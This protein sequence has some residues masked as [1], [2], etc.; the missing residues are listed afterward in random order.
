LSY[1][2]NLFYCCSTPKTNTQNNQELK[3]TQN[4]QKAALQVSTEEVISSESTQQFI[5]YESINNH[6]L[7][8]L[9]IMFFQRKSLIFDL[10]SEQMSSFAENFSTLH[11]LEKK[12]ELQPIKYGSDYDFYLTF[13]Q[14][15]L[16]SYL[17]GQWEDMGLKLLNQQKDLSFITVTKQDF[18][19][20][21]EH[22]GK[23]TDSGFP[24]FPVQHLGQVRFLGQVDG[25]LPILNAK[26]NSLNDL[27]IY[28]KEIKGS[29]LDELKD[30]PIG[31]NHGEYYVNS[32]T[33]LGQMA[34]TINYDEILDFFR[35]HNSTTIAVLL[36]KIPPKNLY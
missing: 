9:S 15:L 32:K 30:I 12:G 20:V 33:R 19:F 10:Q 7:M 22:I 24:D 4:Q 35:E 36:N 18:Y 16:F 25:D 29:S 11:N 21:I 31:I 3:T 5:N 34:L 26:Y 17:T 2:F 23:L 13:N 28:L 27:V 6:Y 14:L 1:S 8:V